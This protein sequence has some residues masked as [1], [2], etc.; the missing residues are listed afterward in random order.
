MGLGKTLAE[1]ETITDEELSG[2]MAFYDLE[3][4]GCPVEDQRTEMGLS[5]LYAINTKRTT[6]IPRFI[7][8]DP[9]GRMFQPLSQEELEDNIVTFFAGKTIKVEA[10]ATEKPKRKPRKD[11]GVKRGSRPPSTK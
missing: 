10:R 3:P 7:D 11:K 9:E 8:R 4:W 5:L 1:I 6:K 2:W